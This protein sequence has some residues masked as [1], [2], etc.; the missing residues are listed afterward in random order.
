MKV[1]RN[2][3]LFER[4]Q[5]VERMNTK[6]LWNCLFD[7]N[8]HLIDERIPRLAGGLNSVARSMDWIIFIGREGIDDSFIIRRK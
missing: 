4:L 8:G 6:T 2:N 3:M 1:I 7:K 5:K